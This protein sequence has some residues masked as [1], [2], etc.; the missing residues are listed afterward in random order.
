MPEIISVVADRTL[1]AM[2]EVQLAQL[3][4]RLEAINKE[5]EQT[6]LAIENIKGQLGIGPCCWLF[7]LSEQ[8]HINDC[9][10]FEGR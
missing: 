2:Q 10:Y 4:V 5:R 1:D 3:R 6:I 7:E 8:Y 9:E